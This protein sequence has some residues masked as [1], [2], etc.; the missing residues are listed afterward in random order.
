MTGSRL[1]ARNTM[2]NVVGQVVPMLAAVVAIPLLIRALGPARFGVLTLA[3][4]AIGY[5]SLFDLGLG[6]ALTQLVAERLGA[7]RPVDE[8]S[9]VAWT[10]MA[11]MLALGVI[12]AVV[13][14]ALTPVI[15]RRGL[16]IPPELMHETRIA[17]YLLAVSLPCVVATAGLRGLLEAHQHFGTANALR[18]P[19]AV[20]TFVGPLAVLPY[21]TSLIAVTSTLVVARYATFVAHAVVC[22]RR[23]PELTRE[24]RPRARSVRPL[25]RT[26]GWMTVSNVVS[27]LMSYLDRFL[28]G[29]VFP[30]AVVAYYVTP[31]ELVSRLLILPQAMLA[32]F[33]PA[34][35]ATFAQNRGRTALLF[36]SSMRAT[37]LIMFPVLFVLALFAREGLTI[38]VGPEFAAHGAPV[39][40]WLCVGVFLNALAQAP[41][42]VLQGTGRSD[43]TAALH[44]LELPIYIA[45]LWW[46]AHRFGLVGVA[47][48]W[49]IR[50]AIDTTVLTVLARRQFTLELARGWRVPPATLI[51]VAGIGA[52]SLPSGGSVKVVAALIAATLFS[53]GAWR[54]LV[55]AD[56][57]TSIRGITDATVLRGP[58]VP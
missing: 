32:A 57:R 43:L 54:F 33:F 13:L 12:G 46:L 51:L 7:D 55:S 42:A 8:I 29:G 5:F 3:Q 4:A 44:V 53:L 9:E 28:I 16:N 25:I 21:S 39:L 37:M 35:A 38:W 48:A 18:V 47:M 26:G 34:F 6:R 17:F 45:G 40:Q 30:L 50:V 1:I 56:E 52:A 2:L 14:G 23:Y 31:Y 49:T 11:L 24:S 22:A 27:P 36:D 19:L 20:L 58:S 41:F 10:A 15:V